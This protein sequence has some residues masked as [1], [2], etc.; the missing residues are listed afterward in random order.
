MSK[1]RFKSRISSGR[2]D[3]RLLSPELRLVRIPTRFLSAFTS[4]FEAGLSGG[5]MINPYELEQFRSMFEDGAYL[6]RLSRKSNSRVRIEAY[7]ELA[8]QGEDISV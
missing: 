6:G 4:G 3:N 8:G 2:H 5:L 7:D 1:K